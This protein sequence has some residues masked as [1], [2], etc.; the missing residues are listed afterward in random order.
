MDKMYFKYIENE[1]GF[2]L[3]LVRLNQFG[4]FASLS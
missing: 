3:W 2:H 1:A 4:L